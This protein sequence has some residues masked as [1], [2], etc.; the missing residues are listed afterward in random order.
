[1]V[2]MFNIIYWLVSDYNLKTVLD[3]VT[4][5]YKLSIEYLSNDKFLLI[6]VKSESVL[7]STEQTND[8][9]GSSEL[10]KY[11]DEPSETMTGKLYFMS[12]SFILFD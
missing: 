6:K 10:S 3:I 4:E 7:N 9:S 8:T 1:M 2:C 12:Y 11:V 5:S